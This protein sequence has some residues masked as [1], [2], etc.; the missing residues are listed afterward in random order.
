[1]SK[2]LIKPENEHKKWEVYYESENEIDVWRYDSKISKT[3]P[4]EVETL[5]KNDKLDAKKI[6]AISKLR[7][8]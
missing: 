7:N 2:K 5:S 3:N 4:S 1:M 8:K 6:A